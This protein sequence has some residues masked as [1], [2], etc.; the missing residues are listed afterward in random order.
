LALLESCHSAA[1]PGPD[2]PTGDDVENVLQGDHVRLV[3]AKPATA[4]VMNERVE[5]SELVFGAGAFWLRSGDNARR[6]TKYEPEK[7]RAFQE[8]WRQSAPAE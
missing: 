6:Y 1:W 5:F 4:K 7:W 8:W 2:P 3:F